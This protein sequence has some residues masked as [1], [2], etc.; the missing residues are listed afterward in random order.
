MS[1]IFGRLTWDFI[2]FE[3]IT[4]ANN[5]NPTSTAAAKSRKAAA[6]DASY[7]RFPLLQPYNFTIYESQDNK[8]NKTI[9][10]IAKRKYKT[11]NCYIYMNPPPSYQ[12]TKSPSTGEVST[13]VSHASSSSPTTSGSLVRGS[14]SNSTK[15]S[16]IASISTS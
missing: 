7:V 4:Q 14:S 13:T 5:G 12:S 6:L 10:S 2:N 11:G 15:A 3:G 9:A 1:L 16:T 8:N